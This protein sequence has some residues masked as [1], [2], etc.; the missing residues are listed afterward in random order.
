MAEKTSPSEKNK[1]KVGV[2][3]AQVVDNRVPAIPTIATGFQVSTTACDS[4]KTKDFT[5][6]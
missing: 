4:T 5:L 6:K 1:L 3:C 2:S